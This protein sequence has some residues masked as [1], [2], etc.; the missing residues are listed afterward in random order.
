MLGNLGLFPPFFPPPP[1]NNKQINSPVSVK[2]CIKISLAP[3][4]YVA[5]TALTFLPD[6][7][8]FP[9]QFWKTLASPRFRKQHYKRLG[10]RL[11]NSVSQRHI[12]FSRPLEETHVQGWHSQCHAP[13]VSPSGKRGGGGGGR[14]KRKKTHQGSS[15]RGKFR[16]KKEAGG[17]KVAG[18]G[19]SQPERRTAL[20]PLSALP[21]HPGTPHRNKAANQLPCRWA[22]MNFFAA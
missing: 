18:G 2:Q 6:G 5:F 22:A 8:G 4:F 10:K 15:F 14:E 7:K 1:P 17:N 21:S 16:K 12:T 9:E 3:K 13:P 11:R 19:D 20:R